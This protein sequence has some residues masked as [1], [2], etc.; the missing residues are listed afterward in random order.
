MR[1]IRKFETISSDIKR[2]ELLLLMSQYSNYDYELYILLEDVT[3]LKRKLKVFHI[4]EI[5]F[6]KF[7]RGINYEVVNNDEEIIYKHISLRKLDKE[8]QYLLF[9]NIYKYEKVGLNNMIVNRTKEFTGID[10]TESEEYKT[11]L[12]EKTSDKYNL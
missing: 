9:N 6:S 2:G 11:F 8:E 12:L 3:R 5:S 4:A 10:I 7:G 1:Y